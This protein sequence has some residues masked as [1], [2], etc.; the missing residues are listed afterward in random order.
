MIAVYLDLSAGVSSV[1]LDIFTAGS[2][3]RYWSIQ[4]SQIPCGTSYTGNQ[5]NIWMLKIHSFYFKLAA[6][7]GCLQW[8]TESSGTI[9]SFNYLSSSTPSVQQ[10]ANQDYT[11]CIRDN[12][13]LRF[14]LKLFTQFIEIWMKIERLRGA[15]PS[16]RRSTDGGDQSDIPRFQW[17]PQVDRTGHAV[18]QRF[19]GDSVCYG[20][21]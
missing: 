7:K 11:I 12:E 2:D 3:N 16:L 20:L 6:P 4:V 19:L 5:L 21:Q 17:I 10:L 14:T 18:R 9:S 15:V 13:V 1:S 8:F